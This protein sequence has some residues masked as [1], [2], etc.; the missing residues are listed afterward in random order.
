ML[1]EVQLLLIIFLFSSFFAYGEEVTNPEKLFAM[2]LEEL[3]N[4]EIEIGTLSGM[5]LS[6]LPF[7]LTIITAE[8]IKNTPARNIYDL[9]EVYV[10]GALWRYHGEGPHPGIRGIITDRNYKLLVLVN[11]RNMNQKAH[12]GA[13][14]ELENWD[15]GDIAKIEVIRGPG[16][17][18]HGPGAIM[19]IINIVT[20]NASSSE[21]TRVNANYISEYNSQGINISHG[22]K[23]DNFDLYVYGSCT[24]TSGIS[25]K[26][27]YTSASWLKSGYMGSGFVNSAYYNDPQQ[28]YFRD[29]ADDPQ[30][31]FYSECNFSKGWKASVRYVNSGAPVPAGYSVY[32]K[33]KL[34]TGLD[35]DA[36]IYSDFTNS[37]KIKDEHFTIALE[38]IHKFQQVLEGLQLK[39]SFSWDSEN[40]RRGKPPTYYTE[41]DSVPLDIQSQL[42]DPNSVR[43]KNA[44]FS[45]DE[46]LTRIIASL[47]IN[48]KY[49]VT[50][51]FE[52]SH[53]TWGPEWGK[54]EK[55]MRLGDR[56]NIISGTDSNLYG[57]KGGITEGYFVGK[58]W[59]TNMISILGEAT[60]KLHPKLTVLLSGREDKD[61]YSKSLFSPRIAL[62]SEL[63]RQN[64]VKLIFQKSN[65]MNTAEQLLVEHLEGNKSNPEVLTGYELIYTR[66]QGEHLL[67]T[68]SCFYNQ[69]DVIAWNANEK[70]S[71][72]VG[73][74][75][76]GGIEIDARYQV[77]NV[78]LGINHSYVKQLDWSLAEG[79]ETSGISYSDYYAPAQF[80]YDP[81]DLVLSSTG[82]DLNN[83][84]NH[85][86][87][88]FGRVDFWQNK[89]TFH[90]DTRIFWGYEGSKDGIEMKEN[91]LVGT[92]YEE[93]C[94]EVYD[95]LDSEGVF[96][97]DFR[98]D[99][100][101]TWK[102]YK[103]IS[104]Q[105]YAINLLGSGNNK[106]YTYDA[107]ADMQLVPNE[108]GWVEEPRD[109]GIRLSA[110]F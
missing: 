85:A 106:R 55:E 80:K 4:I 109:T 64:I 15:L 37:L 31:K 54:N 68:T 73:N 81:T 12:N 76:L 67:M 39:S 56:G 29:F 99:A 19:G 89:L 66:L 98:L 30:Y 9:L 46:L 26:G 65:R 59:S 71:D 97:P 25:P 14:S 8:D 23:K 40:N 75:K 17:V 13:M 5:E 83:W 61:T 87:K 88:L 27:F 63:N 110:D 24:R 53:T 102:F 47:K 69:L 44:S 21:G 41:A 42:A 2:S 92:E 1:K 101:L 93:A 49:Q 108:I 94:Q 58:G 57:G 82:N 78:I 50:L 35:G 33:K 16:S 96:D 11:G 77:N 60:L 32:V 10:P 7:S 70:C 91:A 28:D 62:I 45:E 51:G 79:L 34:Q 100:S 90:V 20:R 36:P 52:G 48:S 105:L 84:A 95:R 3:M 38:N 6:K 86:T 18:T 74:L 22:F 72:L 103:N 107:S 43:N 104:L